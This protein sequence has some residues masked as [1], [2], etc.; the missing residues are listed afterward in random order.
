MN[1]VMSSTFHVF[2]NSLQDISLESTSLYCFQT[3]LAI[4][5]NRFTY[6]YIYMFI[7]FLCIEYIYISNVYGLA[8]R[9][10]VPG[11]VVTDCY[12]L[13]CGCMGHIPGPL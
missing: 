5:I 10:Q 7:Y 3:L 13:L 12:E 9:S 6:V 8:C 1:F 4:D 11:S 2:L